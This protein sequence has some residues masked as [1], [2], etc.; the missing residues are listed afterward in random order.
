MSS[1]TAEYPVA[2]SASAPDASVSERGTT[3]ARQAFGPTDAGLILMAVIWGVNFSVVKAGMAALSPL[4]FT[5]IRMTLAAT[6]LV[7]IA[8]MLRGV[9]WPTR[10]DAWRLLLLGLLG[11]GLYQVLFIFGL[12][13]TRAGVAAL[14]IAAGPAWIAIISRLLGRERLSQIAAAGIGL[15]LVGV[16]CVVGSTR[17]FDGGGGDVMLGAALI[18]GGSL[19]W[20]L[21][22]VLLQPYTMR[23]HPMH[24][25]ALTMVSGAGVIL[26]LGLPELVR[27][28]FGAIP[29]AAWG[30]IVY[31]ALLAMVLAYLLFYRGVKVLGPTRT[32]MYGNLQPI[33]A[34]GVAWVTLH[35]QPT[36][37]QLVGTAF[38][39]GGLL[40]SRIAKPVR[41]K[42]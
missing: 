32:A 17:G 9:A 34:L 38:I 35:E 31:S 23:S 42:T 37:W 29:F 21:F 12:S 10:R 2:G 20:A 19:A 28:D 22:S 11:N 25:S 40:L 14:I 30:A 27:L 39:M 18:A 5:A 6:V 36:G 16:V 41:A 1:S 7:A 24:L 4:S 13:R 8:V 15:Q 26:L 33:I 3:A